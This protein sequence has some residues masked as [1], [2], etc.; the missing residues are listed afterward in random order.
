MFSF[1]NTSF[2]N[3]PKWF[4]GGLLAIAAAA[5]GLHYQDRLLAL[6]KIPAN[7]AKV[8]D[9]PDG[10]VGLKIVTDA[11]VGELRLI[12]SDGS[13]DEINK[14]NPKTLRK[15]KASSVTDVARS[16][17]ARNGSRVTITVADGSAIMGVKDDAAGNV[18]LG[19]VCKPTYEFH[20]GDWGTLVP[21]VVRLMASTGDPQGEIAMLC[22][23]GL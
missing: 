3:A 15:S 22:R 18:L 7:T 5:A 4:F 17:I 8:P 20:S 21:E 10:C 19:V 11:K 6:V 12:V 23:D 1:W 13:V 9:F 14:C 16:N 2:P